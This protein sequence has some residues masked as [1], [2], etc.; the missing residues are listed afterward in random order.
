MGAEGGD[1]IGAEGQEEVVG[2]GAGRARLERE[3]VV[4]EGLG[5]ARL[6][7]KKRPI[8]HEEIPQT[9]ILLQLDISSQGL[10]LNCFNTRK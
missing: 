4:G 3:K 7:P 5:R 1:G 8:F 6:G 2:V 10:I 9:R